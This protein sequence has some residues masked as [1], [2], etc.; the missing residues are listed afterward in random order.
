MALL[1]LGACQEQRQQD[2]R[3]SPPPIGHY[4]GSLQQPGQAELRIAFDIRHPSPGHYEAEL[5]VPQAPTLS[6][7]ADTIRHRGGQL[8]LQRPGRSGQTL[9]LKQDGDFWR[10]TLTLDSLKAE[11]LLVKRGQPSPS[12][13]RVEEIPQAQGSA[14]LFGPA[15][16]GTPGPA[17]AL[18]P[19]E[20]SASSAALWADALAREGFIVLVLPP[21]SSAAAW[22]AARRLLHS[23]PGADTATVG[24]WAVGARGRSLPQQLGAAHASA[25]FIIVQNTLLDAGSRAGFRELVRHRVPV[26]GLYGGNTPLT[27]AAAASLRGALGGRRGSTVRVYRPAGADLLVPGILGPAFVPALPD[28]LVKWLRERAQ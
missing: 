13:Y 2:E 8:Q 5:S 15:D 1:G 4:E 27:R 7:V 28:E 12:V 17:L 24:V 14:W 20:A 16:T 21:D 19:D 6:F 25:A 11:A 3:P 10:G 22:P 26:L 9:T 23:T 18:L